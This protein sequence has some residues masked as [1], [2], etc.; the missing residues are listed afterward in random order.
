MIVL[1]GIGLLIALIERIAHYVVE[2]HEARH[3][4]KAE[5]S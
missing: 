4:K 5:G 3:T 1:T 2:D